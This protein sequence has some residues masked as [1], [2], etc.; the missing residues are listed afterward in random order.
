MQN[1]GLLSSYNCLLKLN[2]LSHSFSEPFTENRH[3][4]ALAASFLN[5]TH[6]V[7]SPLHR[8]LILTSTAVFGRPFVKRFA[9]CY[10]SVVC[11]VYLSVCDVRALWP[12]SWTDQDETW[13]TGRPRPWPH[14]VR[15]G[16]SSPPP[17]GHSPP[18]FGPYLLRP[19]EC[20]DQD[21]TWLQRGTFD[22][23]SL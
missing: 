16:P 15:W 18:I 13:D 2:F 22:R 7:L 1:N 19:N 8:L 21:V 20:M 12:N 11:P 5:L 9:L 17:K 4:Y 23:N 14:C 6:A 3:I 10:R